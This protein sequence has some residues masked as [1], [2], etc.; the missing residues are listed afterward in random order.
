MAEEKIVKFKLKKKLRFVTD[1]LLVFFGIFLI[2]LGIHYGLDTKNIGGTTLDNVRFGLFSMGVVI[3][4][5]L[6]IITVYI[7]TRK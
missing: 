3:S 6:L 5:T 4:G 7:K 2:V 1:M